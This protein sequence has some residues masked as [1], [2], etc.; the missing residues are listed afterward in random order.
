ME[1]S[2]LHMQHCKPLDLK[3][4]LVR[5]CSR[6]YYHEQWHV[7]IMHLALERWSQEDRKFKATLSYIIASSGYMRS[8]YKSKSI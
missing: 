1:Y 4:L 8:Y 6:I 5:I 2:S 7:P 3:K